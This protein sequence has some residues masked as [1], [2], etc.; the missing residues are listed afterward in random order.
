MDIA[1]LSTAMAMQ[2]TSVQVGIAV[3]NM[4][5]DV[6]EQNG[7]GMIQMMK[8]MELSINPHIGSNIDVTL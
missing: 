2:N 3:M 5:K 7:A 8:Q 4:G 6:V 1:Q